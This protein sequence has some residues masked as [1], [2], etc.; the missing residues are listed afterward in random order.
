M[1]PNRD[2]IWPTSVTCPP[3]PKPYWDTVRQCLRRGPA[4][5]EPASL[6]SAAGSFHPML[7]L[8]C[9]PSGQVNA[10]LHLVARALGLARP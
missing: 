2:K 1:T 5:I 10:E 8:S 4:E 9:G 3:L 6:R 7:V